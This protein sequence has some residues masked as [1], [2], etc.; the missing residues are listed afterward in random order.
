MQAAALAGL[1]AGLELLTAQ[2]WT[3]IFCT[4]WLIQRMY[5]GPATQGLGPTLK[6]DITMTY[7]LVQQSDVF[8]GAGL[9][10]AD[11]PG[12]GF[13]EKNAPLWMICTHT[14]GLVCSQALHQSQEL[15]GMC[16]LTFVGVGTVPAH[17][18]AWRHGG[19]VLCRG[20][21][22]EPAGGIWKN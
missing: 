9:R 2:F 16:R 14:C 12:E 20:R 3:V 7:L 6:Y 22:E 4:M 10:S 11:D 15:T 21:V 8:W 17:A 19:S 5:I 1:G 13:M 18:P